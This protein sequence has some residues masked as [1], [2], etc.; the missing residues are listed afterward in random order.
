MNRS[1]LLPGVVLAV[2]LALMAPAAAG[3]DD[4]R[5]DT[6]FRDLQAAPDPK[7]ADAVEAQ[8]W[9]IWLDHPGADVLSQMRKGVMLMNQENFEDALAA[10]DEVVD[11]APEYAEGWNKHANANYLLGNYAEAVK[12]IRRVLALEPRHFAALAGLGLVYL[13]ID[14]PA[15]AIRA[16]EAALALNPHLDPVREQLDA[17]RQQVA[18]V[19]M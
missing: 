14:K 7:A 15:A 13:E 1:S 12:D 11:Q 4:P 18:G 8:I 3:S 19:P 6:L 10:F 16:F 17:L 5:L 9:S 2:L